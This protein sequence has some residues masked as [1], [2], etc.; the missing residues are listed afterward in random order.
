MQSLGI[1]ADIEVTYGLFKLGIKGAYKMGQENNKQLYNI[2]SG[3][4]VPRVMA[5]LN[6][7]DLESIADDEELYT[8][9]F[10]RG[11]RTVRDNIIKQ[12]EMEEEK[13]SFNDDMILLEDGDAATWKKYRNL[14]LLLNDPFYKPFVANVP[15]MRLVGTEK[16]F[17]ILAYRRLYLLL[18]VILWRRRG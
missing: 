14:K 1:N 4:R 3:Y 2:Y 5:I 16:V 6:S 17:G 8:T 13:A 18:A 9:A 10:T 11:F 15:S 12:F 7:P